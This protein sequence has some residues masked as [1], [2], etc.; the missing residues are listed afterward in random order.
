MSLRW[1]ISA[2]QLFETLRP[3]AFLLAALVSTWTLADA[4]R[5]KLKTYAVALWTIG[6]LA[7][8]FIA[9][10]LYL[11]A[12]LMGAQAAHWP[13]HSHA[14]INS[15]PI[16][17]NTFA[18][19]IIEAGENSDATAALDGGHVPVDAETG[20]TAAPPEND[21]PP[22]R[23]ASFFR[24]RVA[25]PFGYLA[26][27]LALAAIFFYRDYHSLDAHLARASHARLHGQRARA[28]SEYRAA[29]RWRDDPHMRKLLG[30]ELAADQ[31]WDQS[32]TELRAAEQG[33][34]PDEA[35]PYHLATTLDAL[36]RADE[37]ITEYRKFLQ[38]ELCA[39]RLL[40]DPRCA[41]SRLRVQQ[42]Q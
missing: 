4:R 29:L 7:F 27:L 21:A 32:L 42:G 24:R 5:R 22:R 20:G 30:L 1:Q 25:L 18:T 6:T 3:A 34:E 36:G 35:L 37:A 23:A 38:S 16:S 15:S 9:F 19:T 31:Q 39:A 33:G 41:A 28:V 11:L 12:R 26:I 17:S 14:D 8:P 40:P 10:P 13:E 2:G